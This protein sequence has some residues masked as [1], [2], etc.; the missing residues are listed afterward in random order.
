MSTKN[1]NPDKALIFRI[2]H[3]RNVPWILEYGGLFARSAPQQDPNYVNIG[4]QE[5]ISKR[6][7]RTVP[8]DPCGTLSDYI[9]FYFT[10]WSIMMYNLKTGYQGITQRKNEEIVIFVSTLNEVAAL[11]IPF[12]FTN[13]HAYMIE[14]DFY[15]DLS[16]L[17]KIDWALLQSKDFERD[18]DDLYKQF[19][20]QAEALVH[21][22]VPLDALRAIVC[23]NNAEQAK[24]NGLATKFKR[25]LEIR[26]LPQFYF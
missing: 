12:V 18:P 22:H 9:P 26:T 1:L 25:N 11:N 5:L 24:L 10:P 14:A 2:V 19:R 20:Y 23:F 6:T 7:Q 15:N 13:G 4:S 8:I 21:Q 16:D 17:D 3:T